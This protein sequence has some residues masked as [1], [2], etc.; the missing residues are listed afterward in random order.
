MRGGN[1]PQRQ[2]RRPILSA[3][4]ALEDMGPLSLNVERRGDAADA[5]RFHGA[6]VLRLSCC[7]RDVTP[8]SRAAVPRVVPGA[9]A[10]TSGGTV[11]LLGRQRTASG[12]RTTAC[13]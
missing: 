13:W 12:Q 5:G 8:P 9:H 6:P 7:C 2:R 10:D 11:V 1:E 4:G 3:A